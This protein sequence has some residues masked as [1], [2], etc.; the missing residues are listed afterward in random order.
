MAQPNTETPAWRFPMGA[1]RPAAALIT[2]ASTGA[3][4][5]STGLLFVSAT[6]VNVRKLRPCL[7]S[8]LTTHSGKRRAALMTPNILLN[9]GYKTQRADLEALGAK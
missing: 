9:L 7:A 2:D 4:T 6:E 8:D 1:P 5:V 3:W